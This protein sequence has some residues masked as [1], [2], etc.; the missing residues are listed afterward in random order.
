MRQIAAAQNVGTLEVSTP[1]T[2]AAAFAENSVEFDSLCSSTSMSCSKNLSEYGIMPP[3]RFVCAS[4]LAAPSLLRDHC[5]VEPIIRQPF[6]ALDP[7]IA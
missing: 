1:A 6:M 4:A 5:V 7:R 3:A 2:V